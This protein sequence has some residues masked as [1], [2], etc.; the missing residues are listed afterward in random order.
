M[1]IVHY[2]LFSK[3]AKLSSANLLQ[4]VIYQTYVIYG[5]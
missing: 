4:K 2:W 1:Y 5:N 3:Y